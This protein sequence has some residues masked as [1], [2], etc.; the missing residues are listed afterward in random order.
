MLKLQQL[1]RQVSNC[2]MLALPQL[3]SVLTE[4]EIKTYLV[5][6]SGWEH[7]MV[8]LRKVDAMYNYIV[9]STAA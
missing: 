2:L 8:D 7:N 1:S 9:E 3:E 5:R 4:R 6:R